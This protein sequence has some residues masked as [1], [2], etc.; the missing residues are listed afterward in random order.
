MVDGPGRE[1]GQKVQISVTISPELYEWAYERVGPGE[2]FKDFTH[3]IERGLQCL[4][5]REE[6]G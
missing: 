1:H 6:G 3:A 2:Q 5:E 4:R